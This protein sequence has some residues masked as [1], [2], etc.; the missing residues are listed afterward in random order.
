[1]SYIISAIATPVLVG[2]A[3]HFLLKNEDDKKNNKDNKTNL[4]LGIVFTLLSIASFVWLVYNANM[5]RKI[6]EESKIP[7]E[8]SGMYDLIAFNFGIVIG[9]MICIPLLANYNIKQTRDPLIV[10]SAVLFILIASFLFS[11]Y[12]IRQEK[13]RVEQI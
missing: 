11:F 4:I 6:I 9:L 10:S 7:S 2:V 3:S 13:V 5:A 8:L 12:K 1:M